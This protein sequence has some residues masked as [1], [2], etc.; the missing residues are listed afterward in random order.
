MLRLAHIELKAAND[1]VQRMHRHHKPVMGH[2]FSL[3][4]VEDGRL[5]GVA[6]VGRPVARMID[7]SQ[8]VEV[9]RCCTDGTHNA[10]SFLYGAC[11]RA[12]K[13]LG[14]QRIITYV[15][16]SEPGTSLRAAGWRCC[17][18]TA[19]GSWNSPGRPR[20]DAAPTTP[21]KLFDVDLT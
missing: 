3:S 21:K 18:T 6:I 4:C 5:C 12:A 10:C 9:L 13:A 15:L 1:F 2:R 17:Y 7:Q 11:R 19:G 14:Y 20:T 16:E 8:T